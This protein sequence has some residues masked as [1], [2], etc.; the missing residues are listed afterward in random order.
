M[1]SLISIYA[2]NYIIEVFKLINNT[3]ANFGC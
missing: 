2:V 3:I 1:Y